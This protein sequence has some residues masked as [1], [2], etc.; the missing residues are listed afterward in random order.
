VTV[1]VRH[2]ELRE[3]LRLVR[4]AREMLANGNVSE[5]V[6][7]YGS[8][9]RELAFVRGLL[10]REVPLTA[11]A[12]LT[13]LISNLGNRLANAT[14]PRHGADSDDLV[15]LVAD[16]LRVFRTRDGIDLE[17]DQISER[18]RNIVAALIGRFDFRPN[19]TGMAS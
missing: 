11:T 1:D 10:A 16:G 18:A 17:D 8:A 12:T 5:A 3:V 7:F 13:R 4:N 15:E 9:V 6:H 19:E 14:R 2:F